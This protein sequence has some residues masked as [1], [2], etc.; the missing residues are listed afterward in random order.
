MA[1]VDAYVVVPAAAGA[2]ALSGARG[3]RAWRGPLLLLPAGAV[4]VALVLQLEPATWSGALARTQWAWVLVAGVCSAAAFVGAGWNVAGFAPGRLGILRATAVQVAATGLKLVTPAGAGALAVN[5]RLVQRTG[6]GT[7]TAVAAVAGA[8]AAQGIVTVVLLGAVAVVPGRAL[9]LPGVPGPP[10]AVHGLVLVALVG[11]ACVVVARHGRRLRTAVRRAVVPLAPVVRSPRRL[12]QGFGGACLLSL[13]LAGTLWAVTSALGTPVGITDA[14]V[15]V[16]V[17][18]GVGAAVPT[19]GGTGG[20][21]VAMTG[22]LVAAGVPLEAAAPAV[23]LYR[24]LTLWLP[25]P[26]GLLAAWRLRALGA[27]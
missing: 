15:V 4:L 3:V 26:L 25:V 11:L 20:V 18:V 2:P 7:G 5:V 16:L 10:T 17:G 21:E 9:V 12:G 13:A 1:Q 19:P 27:L 8:Q 14:L 23:V 6:G 24:L 22:G